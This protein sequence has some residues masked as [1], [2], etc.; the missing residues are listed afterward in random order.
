MRKQNEQT[1]E[2]IL[3]VEDETDILTIIKRIIELEWKNERILVAI[4]GL[5]AWNTMQQYPARLVIT[6]YNMPSMNGLELATKIREAYPDTVIIMITAFGTP[7][8]EKQAR[9]PVNGKQLIDWYFTKPFSFD[10]VLA[11]IRAGL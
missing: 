10:D 2:G 1:P 11:A 9:H 6:D 4:D 8:V 5:A 7:D 3:L